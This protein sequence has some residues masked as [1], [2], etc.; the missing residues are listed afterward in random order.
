MAIDE[1][2]TV[3]KSQINGTI[4]PLPMPTQLH[5]ELTIRNKSNGD[6]WLIEPED[7]VQITRAVDCV[8]S[9]MTFKVPK[10]PNLNF[11]EGD[12]VNFTLNGGAVFFAMIRYVISRTKIAMLSEL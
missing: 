9:K 4:I 7:G 2:K 3:E 6:L 1:K 11:E 8:P 5:Y 12:T 10:D